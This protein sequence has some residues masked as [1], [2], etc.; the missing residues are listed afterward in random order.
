M[1]EASPL[2]LVMLR[3]NFYRDNYRKVVAILLIMV[4]INAALIGVVFYQIYSVPP[5]Q[6]FATTSDGR[7]I[8]LNPLSDPVVTSSA[9]LQWATQAAVAAYSYNFVDYRDQFQAASEYFTPQ[10]WKNF[11][12]ALEGSRNLDTVLSKKLVVSAVAT[13]APVIVE[14]GLINN[15]YS[16]KVQMPILVT[17]QSS[18]S[19]Y[20]QPLVITMLITRVPELDVPKGIA[21]AQ[22]YAAQQG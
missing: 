4:T 10:G 16:W 13:G 5:T 17:Y 7:I 21:I 11:A 22:F 6:Y 9:L 12:D 19:N 2:E 15:R 8:K 1:T 20:Q 3:N 14:Q 18:S